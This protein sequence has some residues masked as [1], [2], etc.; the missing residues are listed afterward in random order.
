[1]DNTYRFKLTIGWLS[2]LFKSTTR[3][4][5]KN[6]QIVLRNMLPK[7]GVAIDVGAHGGQI[8]R[9]LCRLMSKG[10]VIAV[11]PSSYSRSIL[12]LALWARHIKNA[13]VVAGA[14]GDQNGVATIRTPIKD[15]GDMGYGLTHIDSNKINDNRKF[16]KEIC[17][18]TTLDSLASEV[19]LHRID[20]IKVD[21][22]GHE[23]AFVCGAIHT[24]ARFKPIVLMEHDEQ[25]LQRAGASGTSLWSTMKELGYQAHKM[26][27]INLVKIEGWNG[28][29]DVFWLPTEL[30]NN[31]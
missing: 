29:G 10:T 20:F 15:K 22:E 8:T 5:H 17:L 25:R 31:I 12:R 6:L 14:L 2:H 30:R 11:E 9:L 13:I 16:I 7:D 4:D 3:E 26:V 27:S 19:K 1:M 28:E 18:R 24:L 23:A 21:I